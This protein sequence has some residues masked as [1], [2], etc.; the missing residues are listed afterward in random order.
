MSLSST[1]LSSYIEGPLRT[2]S[3]TLEN[4]VLYEP[5]LYE[6]PGTGSGTLRTLKLKNCTVST[7][8]S[9]PGNVPA[10]YSWAKALDR[11]AEGLVGKNFELRIESADGVEGHFSAFKRAMPTNGAADLPSRQLHGMESTWQE[12]YVE[13]EDGAADAYWE[14]KNVMATGETAN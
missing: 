10:Y 4:M 2:A 14:F 3:L 13:H 1:I 6:F 5:R 9:D 8:D 11:C 7:G 12:A